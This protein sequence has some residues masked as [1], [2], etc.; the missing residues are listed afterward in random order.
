MYNTHNV[1][2][3]GVR[4]AVCMY[5]THNV[6]SQ[7]VRLKVGGVLCEVCIQSLNGGR[8]LMGRLTLGVRP[9]SPEPAGPQDGV[10]AVGP[11]EGVS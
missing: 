6:S 1:S 5:N 9:L 7:G 8:A 10:G 2:S 3:Q 11:G 4:L